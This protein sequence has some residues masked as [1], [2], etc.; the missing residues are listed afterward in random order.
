MRAAGFDR[1]VALTEHE[2]CSLVFE[3]SG[4]GTTLLGHQTPLSGEHFRLNAY[5][6]SLDHYTQPQAGAA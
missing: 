6:E 4:K 3:F 1:A 2:G 5:P